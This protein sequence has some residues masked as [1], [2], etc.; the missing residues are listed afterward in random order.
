MQLELFQHIKSHSR[1]ESAFITQ[2]SEQIL[3]Q[4]HICFY[5]FLV[6]PVSFTYHTFIVHVNILETIEKNH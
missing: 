4:L 3:E 6:F 5:I 1:K 2:F